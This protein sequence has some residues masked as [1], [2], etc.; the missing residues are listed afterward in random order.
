MMRPILLFIIACAVFFNTQAQS[1]FPVKKYPTTSFSYPMKIPVSLVGN[2]GECRPNHFHSG[3]DIRTD[4]KENV[5]VYA[6]GDGF[7]SRVKIEAGGFGNAI[8][9]THGNGYT[10]LYAHLNRF[11]PELES[12]IR[13]KQ[14]EDKSWKQ[15]VY[16]LPHQFPVNKDS[17]I[18]LS[19][20]TGSSQ[21]PHLHLEIRDTKTENPLN[22]LL[23]FTKIPDSKAP[24]I[25]QVALYDGNKSIYHQK[26]QL[27]MVKNNALT[28]DTLLFPSEQMYV[29]ISADDF[30]EIATGTL[31]VYELQL[32]VDDELQFAWQMDD[33]SYDITRY[34]NALADYKTKKNNGPWIQLAHKLPGDHLNV[35][36][37]FVAG[38]GMISLSDKKT[39]KIK[40]VALDTKLQGSEVVFF[41]RSTSNSSNNN[42]TALWPCGKI[43]Q[44]NEANLSFNLPAEA[45]YDAV[46]PDITSSPS[47]SEYSWKYQVHSSDVPVHT[48]F[49]LN[50]KTKK[51]IPESLQSKV[52]VVRYP[53]GSETQKKGKA[54]SVNRQVVTAS[55]RD[56]G[57]YEV[58]IDTKP[59]QISTS[60]KNGASINKLKTLSFIIKDD[61]TSV[62][63][64]QLFVDGNWL[65]VVQKGDVFYYELD[66]HF[67]K[68]K[69][70]VQL[71]A[72]DENNNCAIA[73]LTLTR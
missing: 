15:D 36:K 50:L 6:I 22:P 8:Y 64:C 30:S 57:T 60:L 13:S 18:A 67:P 70:E 19:G 26:P 58:V 72:F 65:R 40:V 68:G 55:V 69:H 47:S 54:A 25:K 56:F 21:G 41:I 52:A 34:M 44:V 49:D 46:C 12:F 73:T 43:H 10:S 62:A 14:Y 9:I 35:Y 71:K 17:F 39:H 51:A 59:P 3:I 37:N 42:C 45:L 16:F 61:V 24:K 33:I 63:K 2:F 48:Y 23:F 66:A 11:F 28:K 4:G 20:N 1:V 29:G 5:P 32:Y 27:F 53:F 38:D 31:G 7:I